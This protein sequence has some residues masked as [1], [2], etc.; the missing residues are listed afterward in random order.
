MIQY[1]KITHKEPPLMKSYIS[2]LECTV[3]GHT[4]ALDKPLGTSPASGKVLF[5]RY[6]LKKLRENVD[7]KI[8]QTRPS[9]M[10]K[11]YELMPVQDPNNVIT[12]GEGDTPLMHA[13]NLARKFGLKNLYVKDEGVNPTGSFKAR[14]LSAAVSKAKENLLLTLPKSE[15]TP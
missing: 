14:G 12:L 1:L 4:Y 10:W 5:P 6:D 13:E 3:T 15:I 2:H 7:P 8:F 11:Y 9:N